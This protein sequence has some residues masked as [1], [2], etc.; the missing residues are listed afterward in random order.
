MSRLDDLETALRN[1]DAAGDAAAAQ[2]LAAAIGRERVSAA[3]EQ[4]P[5]DQY[6]QAAIGERDALKAKGVDTGAGVLRRAVQGVSFNTADEI[7]AGLQTPLEMVKRGTLDPRDGYKYAKAREDLIMDDARKNTGVAGTA[8]EIAG[9]LGSGIGLA[10]AG[11]TFMPRAANAGLLARAGGSAADAAVMGGAAGL[12]E[13]NSASE[14]L[15]NAAMGGALGAGLG[16]GVPVAMAG[17]R[18]LASPITSNI[19]ARINPERFAQS[20]VARA[21]SESGLTPQQI[22]QSVTD[23]A[24]AGQGVFT[25][26]DAMGNAGQRLIST[27][28]RGPGAGRTEVV[29]FLDARQAGQGNR[30]S[31]IVD[32]GLGAGATARQTSENLISSARQASEPFYQAALSRKPVWNERIQQFFDDPVTKKGLREGVAVQR[33][34]ALA[35]GKKFDPNDYAITGFNEAGDPILSG[36]PNMRTINLIKKGW[37]NILEGYRDPVTNKLHLDEYGRALDNV[38]RSFLN[39]IDAV[40][41]DYAKARELYAGPA[42]V[43]DAVNTG[44]RSVGRGRAADNLRMFE[45]MGDASQQGYRTGYADKLSEGFE[46]SA[47]GVNKARGLTSDKRRAELLALSLHQ[48]PVRPGELD[49][50]QQRI[51]RENTMFQTRNAA[52]GNSKTAE[53]LADDA[54]LGV[55]PSLSIAGNLLTGNWRSAARDALSAGQNALSGNTPEVRA[56]LAKILLSRDGN[57][58]DLTVTM[59]NAI[60]DA[61]QRQM[62]AALLG[63][64]G[65]GA[66]AVSPSATGNR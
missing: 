10:R 36:V 18:T 53:N 21:I 46:R 3:S 58:G 45:A 23:A 47:E 64:G 13:G 30:L 27:A 54:A 24:A 62:L 37:D 15:S 42:Q 61:R 12:A 50:L 22:E 4:K 31:Q 63:R 28:A 59:Q 52:T 1:A 41:P 49:P 66:I 5:L 2:A 17:A 9:G 40:N 65:S 39:E 25:V 34:E 8:A 7:L 19:S 16:A 14:R 44:A 20:H 33:L 35:E 51:A 43:R 32:E 29:N 6:Q 56:A 26:A 57:A 11:L 55:S 38:R 60:N 48:G